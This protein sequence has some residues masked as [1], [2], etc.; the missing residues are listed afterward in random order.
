MQEKVYISTYGDFHG[1][2]ALGANITYTTPT[3]GGV[4]ASANREELAAQIAAFE[5]EYLERM[6]GVEFSA[7]IYNYLRNA[8]V[9]EI[10]ERMEAL[11]A[12]LRGDGGGVSPAACYVYFKVLE[13]RRARVT[14]TGV[15]LGADK[16]DAVSPVPHQVLAWGLMV[17]ANREILHLCRELFADKTIHTHP[18][19]LERVNSL[20]V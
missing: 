2:L 4:T 3:D 8:D 9:H 1:V 17:R 7:E 20:G 15:W 13:T 11:L 5:P 12:L 18:A 16:A 6:F 10:E 14:E 19:M